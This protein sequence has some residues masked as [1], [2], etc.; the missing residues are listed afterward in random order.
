MLSCQI[1]EY[2]VVVN[3]TEI[4][5]V[6]VSLIDSVSSLIVEDI[7]WEVI[8]GKKRRLFVNI[9]CTNGAPNS[10][11]LQ[12]FFFVFFDAILFSMFE[13]LNHICLM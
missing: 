11:N 7:N 10:K 13:N 2:G 8:L 9:K 6:S 5:S 4:F 3:E 1:N 12:Q